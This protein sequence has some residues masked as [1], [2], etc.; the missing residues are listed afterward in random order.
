MPV[1]LLYCSDFALVP[2]SMGIE[3]P[4]HMPLKSRVLTSDI[5]LLGFEKLKQREMAS[6]FC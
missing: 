4:L 3:V 6:L 1:F 5:V 2:V